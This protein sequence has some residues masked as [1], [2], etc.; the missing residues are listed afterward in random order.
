MLRSL[1]VVLLLAGSGDLVAASGCVSFPFNPWLLNAIAL[2]DIGASGTPQAGIIEGVA[3]ATGNVWTQSGWSVNSKNAHSPGTVSLY[4]GGNANLQTVAVDNGGLEVAGTLYLDGSPVYGNVQVGSNVDTGTGTS[5]IY[6]NLVYVGTC[7]WCSSSTNVATGTE[8]SEG[9]FTATLNLTRVQSYLQCMTTWLGNNAATATYVTSGNVMTISLS[10]SY[11]LNYVTIAA[12]KFSGIT[13]VNVNG[14]GG[15]SGTQSLIITVPDTSVTFTTA[16]NWWYT[17]IANSNV[18]LN[19]PSATTLTY[20]GGSVNLLAPYAAATFASGTH[21]G[22]FFVQQLLGGG[23]QINDDFYCGISFPLIC[24]SETCAGPASPSPSPASLSTSP[25]PLSGPV[26][27]PSP[28]AGTCSAEE[29]TY[30]SQYPFMDL[31]GCSGYVSYVVSTYNCTETS[32][33]CGSFYCTIPIPASVT[34]KLSQCQSP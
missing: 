5:T 34:T 21:T 28:N 1:G 24:P 11:T 10:P 26:A 4:T 20:S 33:G 7:S 6:G 12:S 14:N 29:A 19:L 18:L 13:T 27:S 8:A 25:S 22:N 23:G 2:G 9:S 15:T 3:V 30:N 32:P 16:L 31:C 17:D